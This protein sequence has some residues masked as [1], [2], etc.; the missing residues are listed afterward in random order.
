MAGGS[1][2]TFLTNKLHGIRPVDRLVFFSQ[3][4]NPAFQTILKVF[5][6][7]IFEYA[8]FYVHLTQCPNSFRI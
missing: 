4:P 6:I 7:L 2:V 1:G 3:L 8:F 5:H